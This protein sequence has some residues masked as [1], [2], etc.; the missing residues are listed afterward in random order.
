MKQ[1]EKFELLV[2]AMPVLAK[3]LDSYL[4]SNDEIKGVVHD[5]INIMND[6]KADEQEKDMASATIVEA[7]FN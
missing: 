2:A 4:K 6:E 3:G 7:L 1:S 5:M